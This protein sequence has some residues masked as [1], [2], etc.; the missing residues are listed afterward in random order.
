LVSRSRIK[1]QAPTGSAT[2]MHAIRVPLPLTGCRDPGKPVVLRVVATVGDFMCVQSDCRA[3]VVL[4]QL[5]PRSE[6]TG[7][8]TQDHRA[9]LGHKKSGIA[10]CRC[11]FAATVY[12]AQ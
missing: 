4:P 1:N 8:R 11:R 10:A 6:S 12:T 5:R 9:R 7:D 2:R 3:A